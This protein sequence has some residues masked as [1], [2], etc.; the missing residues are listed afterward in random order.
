VL[1]LKSSPLLLSAAGFFIGFI[2]Q[3]GGTS[4]CPVPLGMCCQTVRT[5][6]KDIPPAAARSRATHR[7]VSRRQQLLLNNR[8]EAS[9]WERIWLIFD[10]S[11]QLLT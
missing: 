10:G 9:S 7:D 11:G 4:Y 3:T 5:Y 6:P 2:G 8:P 1:H